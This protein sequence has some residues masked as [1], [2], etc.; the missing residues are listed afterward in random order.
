MP[1]SLARPARAEA[2]PS[3]WPVPG[4]SSGGARIATMDLQAIPWRETRYPGVRIHF[5]ASDRASGR[6]VALIAMDPGC[7]YPR[8]LHR[9]TEDILVL[10]GG[11]ADEFGSYTRGTSA[12]YGRGTCHSPVALASGPTCVL[13]TA[14]T[15]GIELLDGAG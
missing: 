10:Q 2:R 13:L 7:G 3:P 11:Y 9:D 4:D 8:H 6:V 15:E 14:A 1:A 12:H 5:Y